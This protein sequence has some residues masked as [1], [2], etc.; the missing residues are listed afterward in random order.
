MVGKKQGNCF[1]F[2]YIF[3]LVSNALHSAGGGERRG[4]RKVRESKFGSLMR[5]FCLFDKNGNL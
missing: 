5:I 3:Y 4:R 1:N 2:F